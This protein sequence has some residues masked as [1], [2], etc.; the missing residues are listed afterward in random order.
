MKTDLVEINQTRKNL[1]V[2]I[3][4]DLVDAQIA[5]VT[6]DL[7]RRARIPGF[8]PGKAPRRVIKQRFKEQ[9]LHEVAQEMVPRALQD[10]M[11]NTGVEAIDT[12]DVRDVSVEE[13]Q[14]LTFTASFETLPDFDPGSFETLALRRPSS[15]VEEAAVDQALDRLRDRAARFDPVEDRGA[16][17]GDTLTVDLDRWTFRAPRA[18]EGGERTEAPVPDGPGTAKDTHTGVDVTLGAKANPPGFDEQLLGLEPGATKTFPVHYPADY[19]ITELAGHAVTY[20][21]TVTALKRRVVPELDDEFAKDLG[22]FDTLATLRARVRADLEQEAR[23]TA[24]RELRGQ[25]MKQLVARVPYEVP[26]SLVDRELDRRVEEFAGRLMDQ[27]IDPRR[28]G[29]DWRALRDSQRQ[30]ATEA[31]GGAMAL[32]Q[33]ARREGLEVL[34]HELEQEITRFADQ[35]GR[36]PAAVR[37]AL[38]KEGGLARIASGLLREKAIDYVMARATIASE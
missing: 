13:G 23:R 20:R 2:E 30:A 6:E 10:A 28:A 21:V 22:Q 24:E 4:S 36:T 33:I 5:R 32:D 14:A 18:N 15:V 3:P 19:A 29:I 8:R 1:R 31:V 27:Q 35:S 17:D 9:I 16:V 12:P 26:A 7:A 25:L 11:R 34:D 38:E 37:A